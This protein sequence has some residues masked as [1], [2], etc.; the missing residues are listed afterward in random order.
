MVSSCK[1]CKVLPIIFFKKKHT[2]PNLL[3]STVHWIKKTQ[4]KEGF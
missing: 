4:T 3:N 1:Y 2:D